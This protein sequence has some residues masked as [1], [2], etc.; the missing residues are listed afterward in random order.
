MVIAGDRRQARVILRYVAALLEGAPMLE[1]MIVKRT[2]ESIELTNGIAIEVHTASYRSTR[3]YTV[4]GAILDELAFWKTDDAAEPDHEI[5][6]ALPPGDGNR[7]RARCFSASR[8]RTRAAACSTRR[9]ASTSERTTP[10]CS[11]GRR[12]PRR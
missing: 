7:S 6:A 8:A 5:V 11:C 3:G 12:R 4:V 2:S 9:T 10:T 1:R